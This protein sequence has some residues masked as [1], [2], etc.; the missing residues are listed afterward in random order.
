MNYTLCLYEFSVLPVEI[1]DNIY[2]RFLGKIIRFK[3]K[4]KNGHSVEIIEKPEVQ[5]AGGV[6]YTPSYI[7][8]YIVKET[9]SKKIEEEIKIVES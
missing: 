2:E 5:K 9:I 1:L 7:V 8:N 4:T 6:Y 3:R